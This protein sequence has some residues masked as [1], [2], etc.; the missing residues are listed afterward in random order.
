MS[1]LSL[2]ERISSLIPPINYSALTLDDLEHPRLVAIYSIYWEV[3]LIM[4]TIFFAFMLYM[5]ITKSSKEMSGYKWYLVHQ[6]TWSYLFDVYIGLW[7]PVP[8]WPFYLTY[9][10]GI[11]SNISDRYAVLQMILLVVVALGMG[12]AITISTFHRYMQASPF[13]FSYK[14]YSMP[15][16]RFTVYI[17]SYV[18][19]ISIVIVPL[20][21]QIPVQSVVKASLSSRHPVAK[22]LFEKHPSTFGYDAALNT[23]AVVVYHIYWEVSLIMTTIFFAFM[24]YVIITKSSKEMSGYKWYL[25]HQLTWSY[26]F[27]VYLGLW[28]PVPFWPFY[29]AY[30]AG[31]FSDISEKYIPLQI[32]LLVIALAGV[33]LILPITTCLILMLFGV[34]WVSA[35]S[36]FAIAVI[37]THAF[38]DFIVLTY[39]IKSYREYVKG[40]FNKLRAKLGFKVTVPSVQLAN[41]TSTGI[42]SHI[43]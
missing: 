9:S 1:N 34:T 5:I 26:V 6:L 29:L 27:D 33:L 25:V 18:I 23:N 24:L 43:R 35:F 17:L 4:T 13:S 16:V 41:A 31:V 19:V 20:V 30:S 3:S 12:F 38:V 7:K 39:F 28:K 22:I 15:S 42:P 14:I 8:L 36:L 2:F 21:S 40:L 32:L 37:G 10:I 11:F